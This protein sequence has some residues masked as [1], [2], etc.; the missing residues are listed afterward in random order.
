MFWLDQLWN[1]NSYLLKETP[2]L[3]ASKVIAVINY[4]VNKQSGFIPKT[5]LI[6]KSGDDG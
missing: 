2:F 6:N 3:D 4:I 5:E 1:F